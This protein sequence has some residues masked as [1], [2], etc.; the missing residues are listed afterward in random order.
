MDNFLKQEIMTKLDLE[1]DLKELFLSLQKENEKLSK[2][3]IELKSKSNIL[4]SENIKSNQHKLEPERLIDNIPALLWVT[5]K[6]GQCTY[7]N[8]QWCN[9]TGTTLEEN[10][11]T[12]WLN[13]VH[14]D[15][16]EK[17]GQIFIDANSKQVP[18]SL[19]YRLRS[20]HGDYRWAIDSGMPKYN[21]GVFSGYNGIVTDIHE[22]KI[23]EDKLKENEQNLEIKIK[24]RTTELENERTA[25]RELFYNTPAIIA[26]LRGS[27]HVFEFTNPGY[28]RLY[29]YRPLDG[30]PIRKALPEIEGQGFF[31]LLDDVYQNGKT[32]I[33]KEMQAMVDSNN[34]GLLEEL[35]FNLIYHPIFDKKNKSVGITVFAF[36]ITEQVKARKKVEELNKELKESESNYK[37]LAESLEIQVQQRT[38]EL[39]NEKES[40]K[41]SE[42]RFKFLADNISQLVWV[43]DSQGKSEYFNQRWYEFTGLKHE[44]LINQGWE[45]IV[46]PD[47]ID[48]IKNK[49]SQS[50]KTGD[51]YQI[52]SKYKNIKDG[53]YYWFLVQAVPLKN[54]QGEIIK[55]FGTSTNIDYHKEIERQLRLVNEE[56]NSFT[57]IASH[58][59]QSP[60]RTVSSYLGLIQ[61]RLKD[62]ISEDEKSLFNTVFNANNTMKVLIEDLLAYSRSGVEKKNIHK[63]D[64]NIVIKEVLLLLD[65]QIKDTQA[66]INISNLCI[67]NANY[68]QMIQLFQN[69]I[70]NSLKYIDKDIQPIIDIKSEKKMNYCLISISDN[71]IGIKEEYFSKIFE[72]FK[73]LHSSDKYSGSG[74]GLATVKRIVE[75]HN[76]FIWVESEV[77]KGTT[78]KISFPI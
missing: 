77:Q 68:S 78:F 16:L 33:G 5:D 10:L 9:Y 38:K 31:E 39:S 53:K 73:R 13:S 12:G 14:P 15:D 43:T 11:G 74:I 58:D 55:W 49:W 29:G 21:N 75:N 56:L 18:F 20:R 17:S 67:I 25:L 40:L 30:L 57:Y 52:E 4:I 28:Q 60:L 22:R 26:I 2:E 24:E 76:G 36:E 41:K 8:K 47:Q 70:S 27:D 46:S 71:G 48:L 23:A 62:K 35:Y 63:V 34:N 19:I 6:D 45:K 7:I 69:I 59:L 44:D 54:D 42:E 64:L 37:A 1:P 66:N 72:P 3:N 32:F 50:L 61:R 65:N 51:P